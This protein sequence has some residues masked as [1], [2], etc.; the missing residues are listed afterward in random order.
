ME[1]ILFF[2]F[3]FF[4]AGLFGEIDKDKQKRNRTEN[5][6][7]EKEIREKQ[8]QERFI[9]VNKKKEEKLLQEKRRNSE[10]EKAIRAGKD[11]CNNCKTIKPKR[12]S[13]G[14]CIESSRCHISF[15]S[16]SQCTDCALKE[17]KQKG[18]DI[19][20]G[21]NTIRPSRCYCGN[22]NTCYGDAGGGECQSC[23]SDD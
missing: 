8:R 22:C 6:R 15:Q 11:V 2:A 13:C 7:R 19:C 10:I 16:N 23:S 4:V 17:A 14:N 20:Y 18:L 5:E 9:Q 12:C 3:L 21:C 1:L